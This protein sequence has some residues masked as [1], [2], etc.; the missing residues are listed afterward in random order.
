M[1][2]TKLIWRLAE[3]ACEPFDRTD[4]F[5]YSLRR[6]VTSLSCTAAFGRRN[7]MKIRAMIAAARSGEVENSLEKSKLHR[8]LIRSVPV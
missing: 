2:G 8:C 7:L 4:V 3:V 6:E 1:I 5:A